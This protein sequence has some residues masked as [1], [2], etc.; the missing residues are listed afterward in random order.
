MP[1][2]QA[3]GPS[4]FMPKVFQKAG[5]GGGPNERPPQGTRGTIKLNKGLQGEISFLRYLRLGRRCV[6]KK[7]PE[8]RFFSHGRV[9]QTWSSFVGTDNEKEPIIEGTTSFSIQVI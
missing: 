8:S 3:N 4:W 9:Q 5:G 6:K 1:R 2:K 7:K